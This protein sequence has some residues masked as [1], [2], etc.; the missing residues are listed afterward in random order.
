MQHH[1]RPTVESTNQWAM[2]WLRSNVPAGPVL[3]T[4]D[5]QTSGRGQRNKHWHSE[6]ERD[7]CMSLV[8]PVQPT[9]H[10]ASLNKRMALAVHSCLVHHLPV[11]QT[12]SAV[13]IK[14]PN[15]VMVW[16][17]AGHHKVAGILVENVWRGSKWSFAV[18]GI[19]LNVQ[20]SRLSRSY[21]AIS[22]SEAWPAYPD[23]SALALQITHAILQRDSQTRSELNDDYAQVLFAVGHV[24]DF[25]VRNQPARGAFLGVNSEG[26]GQFAWSDQSQSS[27]LP[28]LLPSSEVQWCWDQ[29]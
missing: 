9:W 18:V 6:P 27:G 13:K 1:H 3:F 4:T 19:G 2:E 29:S 26:L 14:W 8:L 24:R 5:H 11:G 7:L 20:S 22:L 15:D 17:G 28:E 10:P 12:A 23:R 21:R 25:I 16:H